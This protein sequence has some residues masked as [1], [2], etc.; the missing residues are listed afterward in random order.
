MKSL[1]SGASVCI[2]DISSLH[3]MTLYCRYN[4]NLQIQD[5]ME[6]C[7]KKIPQIQN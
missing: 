3:V 4:K 6:K 5:V 2:R 7:K 1:T